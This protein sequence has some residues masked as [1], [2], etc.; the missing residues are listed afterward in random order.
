MSEVS[1][2]STYRIPVAQEGINKAKKLRLKA[3]VSG[4]DN[5]LV[6]TGGTGYARVSMPNKEDANFVRKLKAIGYK[7]FQVFDGENV[8]KKTI[9]EFIKTK[10]DARDYKQVGKQMVAAPKTA[11]KGKVS[12]KV[13]QSKKELAK[14]AEENRVRETDSYKKYLALYG[15]EATDALFFHVKKH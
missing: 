2:G 8:S 6:G 9:D 7:I 1:F 14:I 10:L 5:H 15:K 12:N 4:F 3:L 13:H 11:V